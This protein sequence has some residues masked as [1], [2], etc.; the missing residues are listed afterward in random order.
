M[1]TLTNPRLIPSLIIAAAVFVVAAAFA[2]TSHALTSDANTLTF[3][4]DVA[5]PGV[6]LPAGSY[7]F[8]IA[9]PDTSHDVVIVRKNGHVQYMGFTLPV[10]RPPRMPLDQP[11]TLREARPDT[12]APIDT[13][14]P[15]GSSTGHQF[16][17]R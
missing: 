4:R 15:L 17:Y 9:N 11:L 16:I 12:A 1:R 7:V 14:F 13:W 5:L 8:D 6:V 2:V 3:N 10:Q